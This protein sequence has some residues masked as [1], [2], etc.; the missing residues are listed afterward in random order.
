MKAKPSDLLVTAPVLGVAA[1]AESQLLQTAR[2]RLLG[3]YRPAP[4][5]LDHGRGCEV[6]D[7]QG[8]RYL[9]FCA[10]VATVCLGHGHPELVRAIAE[11]A[12]QLMHVSNYVYNLESIRLA[13]ELCDA[14][15]FDRAFFCNS[16][17]EANEALLK[18][19]RRHYFE[20]GEPRR[21]RLIAF[22]RSFHGRTMGAL[23]L[24]GNAL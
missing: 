10:G 8:R 18:L 14:T 12:A 3:N 17:A 19:A 21:Q 22:E 6:F 13:D 5:V 2:R 9:D 4:I 15:G 11:Q 20:L 1:G 23:T 24:T 7:T 16:G